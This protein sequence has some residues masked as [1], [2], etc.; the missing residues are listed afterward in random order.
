M[1][2]LSFKQISERFKKLTLPQVDLVVGIAEG[3]LA[4][5]TMAAFYLNAELYTIKINYR[6]DTNAPRYAEPKIF[7]NGLNVKNKRILIVDDV[8]VTG[9]TLQEA[10]KILV[11]N[12]ISTLTMKGNADYV[13]FPEIT[14]CVQWPWKKHTQ[15][16]TELA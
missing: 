7:S 2:E 5:A 6:D 16:I 3:G 13:L 15:G 14:E 4:P 9:K 12:E 11:G 10:K 1:R 8:S